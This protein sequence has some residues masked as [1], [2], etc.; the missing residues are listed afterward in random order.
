MTRIAHGERDREIPLQTASMQRRRGDPEVDLIAKARGY[1]DGRMRLSHGGDGRHRR[2]ALPIDER[3]DGRRIPNVV[4]IERAR[5]RLRLSKRPARASCS[6]PV[7]S[8]SAGGVLEDASAS[9]GCR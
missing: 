5:E 8:L 9:R 2:I 3:R 4:G 1:H 6:S 7:V